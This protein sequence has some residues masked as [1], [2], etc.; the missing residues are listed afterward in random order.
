[1]HDVE[2]LKS[3]L[4]EIES[5]LKCYMKFKDRS[6]K[7]RVRVRFWYNEGPWFFPPSEDSGVKGFF[8]TGEIFFVCQR[9]STRGNIPDQ[10]DLLFYDLLRKYGFEDAH[11][12]DLV[13]CRGIAGKISDWEMRN[14]LPYLEEEIRILK[15]KLMIAVGNEAYEVLTEKPEFRSIR[16]ERVTHYS[17][18][19]RYKKIWKLEEEFRRIKELC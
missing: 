17:H 8:G 19:F 13:K 2:S 11:I 12:T 3:L 18:A 16:I 4:S 6:E 5:C 10:A 9:P 1:M 7:D 14:C 15:P